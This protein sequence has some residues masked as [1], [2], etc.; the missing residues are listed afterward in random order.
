M[1]TSVETFDG[2]NHFFNKYI[3][4][5]RESGRIC[6]RPPQMDPCPPKASWMGSSFPR[7]HLEFINFADFKKPAKVFQ[8]L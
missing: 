5:A 7:N 3:S 4:K 2:F 1:T 6:Q 8:Q